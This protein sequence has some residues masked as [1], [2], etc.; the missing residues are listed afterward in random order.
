MKKH[1]LHLNTGQLNTVSAS[2]CAL[3]VV[4]GTESLSLLAAHSNGNLM[5]FEAW[6]YS[7]TNKAFDQIEQEPRSILQEESIFKLPFSHKH[8]VLFHPNTTIVPRRLFQ[9]GSL[10]GY[11]KLMLKPADYIY[12]Y[13]ELPEFDA[14]LVYATEKAQAKLFQ[15]YFPDARM[16]H[17]ALP[18]LRYFR[19]LAGIENHIVFVNLRHQH[20]QVIVLERKNLLLYNTFSFT[21]A[22]DLLY[23]ILLAYD[24]FRLDP[25]EIPLTLS[26]NILKDSEVYRMLYRFVREIRFA[27]P[28]VQYQIPPGVEPMPGHCHLDLSCLNNQ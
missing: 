2:N 20:A 25:K 16:Q 11:F 17:L 24:Q 5:A 15:R 23:F 4:L 7:K 18:L 1:A 14:Y 13:E 12:G 9:H 8:C 27:V 3:H 6:E 21:T 19:S 10:E 28:P 26:G 22:A